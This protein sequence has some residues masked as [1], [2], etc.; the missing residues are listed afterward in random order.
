LTSN[1][2]V[3]INELNT[4]PGFTATSVFPKMWAASG[5]SYQEVITHL[6]KSAL[7]RNN[8]VLGN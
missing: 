7:T 4:M 3:V 6:L 2:E 8:G 1:G 5:V